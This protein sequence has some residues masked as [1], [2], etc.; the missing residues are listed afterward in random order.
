MYHSHY[1]P[2]A[3]DCP[4]REG[5]APGLYRSENPSPWMLDVEASD[6][7]NADKLRRQLADAEAEIARVRGIVRRLHQS[8]FPET[9]DGQQCSCC[10]TPHART[11]ALY[12]APWML[13]NAPPTLPVREALREALQIA[14][15]VDS[16]YNGPVTQRHTAREVAALQLVE[17]VRALGM[18]IEA[19][20]RIA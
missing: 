1:V 10:V 12:A 11:C 14:V 13:P 19:D 2:C 9:P 3:A 15:D 4:L 8:V 20:G 6:L 5:N 7:R 17:A 18:M 16:I